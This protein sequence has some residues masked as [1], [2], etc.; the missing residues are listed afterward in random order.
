MAHW[1]GFA[2]GFEITEPELRYAPNIVSLEPAGTAR[3]VRGA[4]VRSW[5]AVVDRDRCFGTGLRTRS[6][7]ARSPPMRPGCP[8]YRD[9]DW[10]AADLQ[11]AADSC[12]M[13]AISVV[14]GDA[15]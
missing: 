10:D 3:A 9:G 11:D 5:Y 14:A 4:W 1:P 6:R 2:T 7:P 13:S 15:S 8:Q 12:P